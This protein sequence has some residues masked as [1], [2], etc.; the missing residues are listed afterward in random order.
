MYLHMGP[1][2]VMPAFPDCSIDELPPNKTRA[3]A[4]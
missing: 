2:P 3:V 1:M 4:P